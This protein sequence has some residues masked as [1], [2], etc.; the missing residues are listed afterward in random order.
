ME[1][2]V[3][4]IDEKPL[5]GT[6]TISQGFDR[7]H[8]RLIDLILK[9]EERFMRLG[10][11]GK[12]NNS[13]SKGLIVSQ[14][15]K[16]LGSFLNRRVLIK[17]AGRP[18]DEFLL[19][20]EQTIFLGTLFRNTERVLDFKEQLAR[21]F[22]KAKNTINALSNQRQ[23]KNWINA[24]A[25]GKVQRREE[26][27]IIKDFVEYAK[28]QGS[29]SPDKYYLLFSKL[30]NRT[31]F[32]VDKNIKKIRDVMT[33]SQLMDVKFAEKI[34]GLEILACMSKGIDYHEI[35]KLVK[36][37]MDLLTAIHTKTKV[38]DK[39]ELEKQ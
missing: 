29:K 2:T 37:K 22:V 32:D 30:V 13:V 11:K 26:T 33:V 31:L 20:E 28:I 8:H 36:N 21:D 19:N 6:W 7:E 25:T 23:S 12:N 3:E 35:Y 17:T 39:L 34:V 18:I 4:L 9:H 1:N 24:R 14:K 5:I 38:I 27:D 15:T 10:R 16:S